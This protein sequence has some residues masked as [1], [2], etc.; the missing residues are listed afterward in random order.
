M[1][2]GVPGGGGMAHG[3]PGGGGPSRIF[4]PPVTTVSRLPDGSPVLRSGIPL[5]PYAPSMTAMFRAA[6]A[7]HPGR[8]LAAQREAAAAD[9]WRTVAYAAARRQV[10]GLAQGL[11]DRCGTAAPPVMILSG[12]SIEHLLLTLACYTAGLPVV[13]VSTAYSLL[14]SDHATRRRCVRPPPPAAAPAQPRPWSPCPATPG[15][16]RRPHSASSRA[17]RLPARSTSGRTPPGRTPSRRSSSRQARRGT[18]RAS[19]TPTG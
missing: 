18:P 3:V 11:L 6:A 5:E 7:A 15:T 2:H 8:T 4:A 12:N 9:G 19:L 14:A 16:R 1:A 10:D 17:R 13:P